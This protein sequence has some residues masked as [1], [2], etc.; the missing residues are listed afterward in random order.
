[1]GQVSE[2]FVKLSLT[3]FSEYS[4]AICGHLYCLSALN[5][6]SQF[7]T[8]IPEDETGILDVA[9]RDIKLS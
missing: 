4:H 5:L 7:V 2:W 3:H 6:R 8:S 1:M 9:L